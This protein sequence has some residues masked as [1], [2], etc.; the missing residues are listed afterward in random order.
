MRDVRLNASRE[1]SSWGG[2]TE[3]VG[4]RVDRRKGKMGFVK[5]IQATRMSVLTG[6][7]GLGIEDK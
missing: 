1:R 6:Q 4:G 7:L 2:I 5:A 3:K